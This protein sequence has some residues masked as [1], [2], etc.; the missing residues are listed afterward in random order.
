M[1]AVRLRL[2]TRRSALARAQSGQIAARLEQLHP[3][4]SVELI[5][6]DTRG[7][8]ILDQPLSQVEGKEFFTAEID[9]ALLRGEVDL[10]VHSYKDLSLDRPEPLLLAAVPERANPRDI[11]VFAADVH[12]QLAAGLPL[13]I[14]SSSPRRQAFVPG[15]LARALPGARAPVQLVD[16]RGNVDSRLRRLRE[17]RG[18]A[19]QLDGVVLAFA[20]LSRLWL[21][22][23]GRVLLD[24]LLHGLPRMVLPLSECPAAPAQGALAVECRSD[25]RSTR[26]LLAALDH[27][28]TRRAVAAERRLLAERGGG[29]HQRFG[30][31]QLEVPGLG[32]L[33][34]WR[35]AP[36]ET[37]TEWQPAIPLPAPGAIVAS[38]DGSEQA[39]SEPIRLP[40]AS[41]RCAA[42][43]AGAEAAFIAHRHALPDFD[44][45]LNADAINRCTHLWVPGAATWF[46]LARRG[47]WVEGCAEGLGFESLR[48]LL[49]EPLLQL[50]RLKDW[51]VL[52]HQ[53]A[54][55]GWT[56]QVL[57]TYRSVPRATDA[58]VG[59]AL[60]AASHVYWHSGAQFEAWRAI[61]GASAHH[62]CGFG[63]TAERLHA[64]G[65]QRLTV[66]PSAREW[67]HWLQT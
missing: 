34:R 53:A 40:D 20:G 26:E 51:T 48:P 64:A 56:A 15:F 4:L 42:A 31:T 62:A 10:T 65:V 13:R 47:V 2:G 36:A 66:F 16:L 7:D 63:K 17:P 25:D 6:I 61:V 18:S 12:A 28:P 60:A 49:A 67:R 30:A 3:D 43:L 39:P 1:G 59:V 14:G 21:D 23:S 44:A 38:W 27:A 8:R 45:A 11:V 9:T 5:G 35:E 52:T 19:R 32:T 24:E 46:D 50:P 33:L 29:C 54:T 58:A 57:A 41:A 55:S 22:P 37:V